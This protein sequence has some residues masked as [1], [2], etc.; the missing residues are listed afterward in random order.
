MNH[1][2]T[3]KSLKSKILVPIWTQNS[4]T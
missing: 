3:M 4:S 2:W 1:T